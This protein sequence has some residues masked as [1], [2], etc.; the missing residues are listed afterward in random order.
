MAAPNSLAPDRKARRRVQL[1]VVMVDT[2]EDD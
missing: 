1:L 2:P